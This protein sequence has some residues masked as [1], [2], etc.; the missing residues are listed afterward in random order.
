MPDD[1]EAG[2]DEG[3]KSTFYELAIGPHE[4]PALQQ[5]PVVQAGIAEPAAGAGWNMNIE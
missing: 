3:G 4:P 5:E 2:G 1:I